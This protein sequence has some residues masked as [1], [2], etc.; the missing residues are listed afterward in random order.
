MKAGHD[1]PSSSSSTSLPSAPAADGGG[2]AAGS[3][4]SAAGLVLAHFSL[5]LPATVA[6]VVVAMVLLVER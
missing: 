2:G 6:T 3:S 5:G 1:L 4:I